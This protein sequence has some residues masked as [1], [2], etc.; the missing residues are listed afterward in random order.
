MRA[1][2][3]SIMKGRSQAVMIVVIAAM[4]P[5][6]YWVSAA[7]VSLITLRR[8]VSDGIKILFWAMLPALLWSL[9]GDPS[10]LAVILA[11]FILAVL[12]RESRSW[13]RV[14]IALVPIGVLIS[15]LLEMLLGTRVD[16]WAEIAQQLMQQPS[17]TNSQAMFTNMSMRSV[18]LGALTGFHALAV[19]LV[20]MLARSWQAALFNPGGF[21]EEFHELRLPAWFAILLLAGVVLGGTLGLDMVRWY[22]LLLMPLFIAGVAWVHWLVARRG[23][24]KTWLITLYVMLLFFGPYLMTLLVFLAL[25]DACFD[26]RKGIPAGN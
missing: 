11:S 25:I 23:F 2:A 1:L 12:L 16:L 9:S 26:L 14:L 17:A 22:A 3:D 19:L 6:L 8:G 7:G 21:R 13:P 24:G 4:L 5:L 20:L 18:V 10:A 15:Y